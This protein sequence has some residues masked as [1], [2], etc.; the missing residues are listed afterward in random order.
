MRVQP[1]KP[2][3]KFAKNKKK[4]KRQIGFISR[5]SAAVVAVDVDNAFVVA[6]AVVVSVAAFC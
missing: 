5:L 2:E 4:K 6:V 1:Q 3:F